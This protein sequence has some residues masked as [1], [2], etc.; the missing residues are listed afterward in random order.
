MSKYKTAVK[1]ET[2]INDLIEKKR[3]DLLFQIMTELDVASRKSFLNDILNHVLSDKKLTTEVFRK[4][5]RNPAEKKGRRIKLSV[6][7]NAMVNDVS[8][9]VKKLKKILG[10]K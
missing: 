5:I 1:A 4:N 7:E 3:Y 8:R 6:Q 9:E 10:G 2:I